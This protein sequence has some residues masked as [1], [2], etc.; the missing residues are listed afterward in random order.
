MAGHG[1]FVV[2]FW[3]AKVPFALRPWKIDIFESLGPLK[4]PVGD[5]GALVDAVYG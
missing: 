2:L 3:E 5:G 1:D 4:M